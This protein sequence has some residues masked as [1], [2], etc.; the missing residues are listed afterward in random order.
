M[1]PIK[2]IF[3]LIKL[4][5]ILSGRTVPCDHAFAFAC[6]FFVMTERFAVCHGKRRGP[7]PGATMR[8]APAPGY[9]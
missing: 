9:S 2:V 4:A 7:L 1:N 8:P 3:A 6:M 5:I